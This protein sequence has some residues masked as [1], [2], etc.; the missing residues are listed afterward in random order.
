[1]GIAGWGEW[2]WGLGH[3][4]EGSFWPGAVI[5]SRFLLTTHHHHTHT[6]PCVRWLASGGRPLERTRVTPLFQL[7]PSPADYKATRSLSS[8]LT[9]D[10]CTDSSA[11]RSSTPILH[12][13]CRLSQ[14]YGTPL[15]TTTISARV[16][17]W[18]EYQQ[19]CLPAPVAAVAN[20]ASPS[21]EVGCN[22]FSHS[23]RCVRLGSCDSY[24]GVHTGGKH[25]SRD[26]QPLN[27][28]GE[29]VGMWGVCVSL[30]LLPIPT[31]SYLALL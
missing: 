2:R 28:D 11:P 6:H 8:L 10:F 14:R 26:L 24:S 12:T 25:F 5:R 16:E 29:V 7:L 31:P 17:Y 4:K 18:T 19:E 13:I 15:T 30:F 27:A 3:Q 9:T 23:C 20:S 1:M 22:S 21:V